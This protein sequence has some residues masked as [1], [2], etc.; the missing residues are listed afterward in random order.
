VDEIRSKK[1]PEFL[2]TG[3]LLI[4]KS[5]MYEEENQKLLFPFIT[6]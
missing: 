2:D 1:V 5:N 6:D 3:S 4:T